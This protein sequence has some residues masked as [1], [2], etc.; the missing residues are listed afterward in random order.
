M[1]LTQSTLPIGAVV[2]GRYIVAGLLGQGGFGAVYL[3][4]DRRVTHNLF[5]LKELIDSNKQER[6]RFTRECELL[7]RLDY[8]AL[9]RVYRVF[10]DNKRGRAYM[11]MDY[12]E[13]PNLEMLRQKQPEKR[14]LLPQILTIMEPIIG[15]I[16]YLHG[17]QP[18]IIHRDIKPANI[19]VPTAGDEAVLV[20]FGTAKEYTSDTTTTAIRRASPCYAA[21]ELYGVGTDFRTDIYELG[22]TFYAL[23]TGVVP[24]DSFLRMTQI[25]SKG[26]DPLEPLRQAASTIP[27]P[28]ADAIYRAMSIRIDDR[29]STVEEFWQ[30]LNADPR[31]REMPPASVPPIDPSPQT[32]I[33]HQTTPLQEQGRITARPIK[34]GILVLALLLL[35]IGL[36]IGAALWSYST[37]GATRKAATPTPV[38]IPTRVTPTFVPTVTPTTPVPVVPA[39]AVSYKG[40]IHNTPA[41]VNSTMSLSNIKQLGKNITGRLTLGPGLIGDGPFTGTVDATRHIQFTIPGVFG[42]AS[43]HFYGTVQSNGSLRGNYCSL[44]QVGHCNQLAGGYGT[45][46][47][48]PAAQQSLL[49]STLAR[50]YPYMLYCTFT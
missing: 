30:A 8:P 34:R 39:I 3:V 49:N 6:D 27:E 32:V 12:I 9:P 36:S 40:A 18:S 7:R 45:W 38:V 22:A 46:N 47:A 10:E 5:A 25:A 35:V 41:D 28:V 1:Q 21:P 4:R 44:D 33:E 13:G 15:A 11:L 2:Q 29:F 17:Q 42:N 37:T 19:V 14:F 26:T 48:T 20:D 50:T 23:L 43:L 24:V 31:W 16:S